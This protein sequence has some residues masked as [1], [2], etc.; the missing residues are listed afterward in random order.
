MWKKCISKFV[1]QRKMKRKVESGDRTISQQG[2]NNC[3]KA[4]LFIP[5]L[6]IHHNAKKRI[7]KQIYVVHTNF[8]N[9][10]LIMISSERCEWHRPY[11]CWTGNT[12]CLH[13]CHAA[14][15]SLCPPH[16]VTS[17]TWQSDAHPD[18][19]RVINCIWLSVTT[20]INLSCLQTIVLRPAPITPFHGELCPMSQWPHV[21]PHPVSSVSAIIWEMDVCCH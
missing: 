10:D 11:L 21:S 4:A 14:R 2:Q 1:G 16:D 18:R 12:R 8:V 19:T 3:N 9:V 6:F 13:M 7:N 17:V 15:G 20:Q 5:I